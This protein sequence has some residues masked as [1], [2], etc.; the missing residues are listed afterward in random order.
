V[1]G[2]GVS[3]CGRDGIDIFVLVVKWYPR[4]FFPYW[5]FDE[6]ERGWKA[7]GKVSSDMGDSC[8]SVLEG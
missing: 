6:S 7:E 8:E 4:C 2:N 5:A 1:I 3:V